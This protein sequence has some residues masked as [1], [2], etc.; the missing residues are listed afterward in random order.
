MRDPGKMRPSFS[1]G[2]RKGW[3]TQ[4]C[5]DGPLFGGLCDC[6]LFQSNCGLCQEPAV[7]RCARL[8]GDQC[9]R[10]NHSLEAGGCS[11]GHYV[12]Y[13]PEDVLGLC[14]ACQ[15]YAGCACLL[16]PTRDLEDPNIVGPAI[17]CDAC[18]N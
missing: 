16:Q 13:L 18:R 7:R 6:V 8:D 9:F 11:N 12:A 1:Q 10:Q 2:A 3:G 4:T 15:G 5:C 17:E 14:S